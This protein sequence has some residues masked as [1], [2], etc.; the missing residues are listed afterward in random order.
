MPPPPFSFFFLPFTLVISA[1]LSLCI[2]VEAELRLFLTSALDRS[3]VQLRN[4]GTEPLVSIE[5]ETTN[6]LASFISTTCPQYQI[7]EGKSVS[8]T[9]DIWIT[10]R[11]P[12]SINNPKLLQTNFISTNI[13][14]TNFNVLN[15]PSAGP[16]GHAVSDVGLRPLA[17]WDCVFESHR[18]HGCLSVVSVVCCQVEVSATGW[19]LVQRSPTDCGASLCVI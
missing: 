9:R 5:Q 7:V 19:S 6:I 18:R 13:L 17:C 14:C 2:S 16:S 11:T 12:R 3:N 15:N 4:S 8:C 10:Q 1:R